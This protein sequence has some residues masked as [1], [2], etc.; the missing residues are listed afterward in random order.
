M[1][2]KKNVY[3]ART[4]LLNRYLSDDK[5]NIRDF[6]GALSIVYLLAIARREKGFTEDKQAVMTRLI[7]EGEDPYEFV[8][9]L[10]LVSQLRPEDPQIPSEINGVKIFTEVTGRAELQEDAH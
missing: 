5:G 6:V 8:I 2:D 10:S 1:T 9:K 4:E 3:A 7:S